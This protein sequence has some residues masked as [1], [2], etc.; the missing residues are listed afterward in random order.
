MMQNEKILHLNIGRCT[1]QCRFCGK[2][3]QQGRI[4]LL[5][6]KDEAR[7]AV[8]AHCH[9]YF[10]LKTVSCCPV[11]FDSRSLRPLGFRKEKRRTTFHL[12]PHFMFC[13]PI[14][15]RQ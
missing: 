6:D 1:T 13:F 15:E 11:F 9:A 4:P 3:V 14:L 5:L 12:Q 8:P 7:T 10:H 2:T